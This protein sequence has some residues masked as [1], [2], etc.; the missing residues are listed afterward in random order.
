MKR[1]VKAVLLGALLQGSAHAG[2]QNV[3]AK[4]A[5]DKGQDRVTAMQQE[6]LTGQKPKALRGKKPGVKAKSSKL[7]KD[8]RAAKAK[9]DGATEAPA[10]Q[11]EQVEESVQL[12]GV[13]G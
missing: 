7:A 5:P 11:V 6:V 10:E 4:P 2:E 3:N 8:A 1:T 12:K 9:Q 13:R